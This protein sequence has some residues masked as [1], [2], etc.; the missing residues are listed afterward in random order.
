[1]DRKQQVLNTIIESGV[2]AVIRADR[3]EELME[4]AEALVQGGLV[5]LEVTMTTPGAIDVIKAVVKEMGDKVIMGAGTVL[6]PET[7]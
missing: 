7:A 5:A 1:M 2:I 4:V 6:D 3:S